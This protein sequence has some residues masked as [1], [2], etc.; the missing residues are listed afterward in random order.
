MPVDAQ[1]PKPLECLFRPKRYKVLYGGRGAGR[2]WN[3]ARALLLI[4]TKR[5]IRV[6]CARELQKS[7]D[8]SVHRLLS[9]QILLLGLSSFYRIEKKKIYGLNGT[10]F[11]FE[12]IR[13][14]ATEI[15]SYEGADYCWVEEA[16][17]VS[18]SSWGILIPTIRK[19]NSEIWMT[20][21]PE[22]DTDYSY[23]R[24]V[25]DAPENSF[26]IKMTWRDNPWFP[27]VLRIEMESDRKRDYDHYLNVWEGNCLQMLEGTVYAKE[28]RKAQDDG[29]I[30][31]VPWEHEI[32]VDTWWDL[33]RADGT[34]IWFGQ[35]VAMQYRL[36]AYYEA[37]GEDINHFL[38][39]CQSR[40]YTYGTFW[41]PHDAKA[42]QLG[43]K[44]TIEE[45][46]RSNGW[47][48]RIVPKL[49]ISDGHNAA[50]L[51]FPN[52]WF[53]ERECEAGLDA[54]RHYR[55]KVHE[56][57]YSDT[58]V[59]DW[60]MRGADAFR[61]FAVSSKLPSIKTDIVSRLKRAGNNAWS[62][63]RGQANG[64]GWMS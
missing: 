29:R 23:T 50:R 11:G 15:K 32:P 20:F 12:G 55:Y 64:L 58:P 52:A 40:A 38:R 2:S 57:Q 18:K 17:K 28:L 7:I 34:G 46:I 13:H 62:K 31:E 36:L 47:R 35:Q 22:L 16:V 45:V 5:P 25:K 33:G 4:G 48:T 6:L 53:D 59:H 30:C 51:V 60:A 56:G 27:E 42:K 19:A 3:V 43:S 39:E 21:N 63:D 8:D 24:F 1:F 26:V 37:V 9:D 61:Y 41:L 49:S 10:E 44:R 14:N 54:L